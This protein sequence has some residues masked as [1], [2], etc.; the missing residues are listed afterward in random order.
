[1]S[2]D[3]AQ[4]A[5]FQ[6]GERGQWQD[7]S[8]TARHAQNSSLPHLEMTL[9]SSAGLMLLPTAPHGAQSLARPPIPSL[10]PQQG[11]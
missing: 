7:P 8:L 6:T 3:G 5:A 9:G 11:D 2:W 4:P 10:S 1:M